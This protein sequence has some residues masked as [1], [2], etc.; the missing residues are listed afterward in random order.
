MA[1]LIFPGHAAFKL[2]FQCSG[3]VAFWWIRIPDRTNGLRIRIRNLLFSL[4]TF[5]INKKVFF[6]LY[7]MY[8][9]QCTVYST[10]QYSKQFVQYIYISLQR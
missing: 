4:V 5:N 6:A 7:L 10:V 3:S 9:V 1:T 8:T 2:H